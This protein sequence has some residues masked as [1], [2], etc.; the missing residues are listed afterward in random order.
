MGHRAA[1][2][3]VLVLVPVMAWAGQPGKAAEALSS[4]L[5]PTSA[6]AAATL[7]SALERSETLR[8]LAATIE[9]SDLR[10]YVETSEEPGAWR[11]GTRFVAVA[12]DV[13]M[14][15]VTLNG[16]LA[17]REKLAVLGHELQHV[18]EV[19]AD[20]TVTSQARMKQLFEQIGHL[21][22]PKGVAREN[23]Y[24]TAA[25][26]RV[27]YQVRVEVAQKKR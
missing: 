26:Q 9:T 5:R 8:T 18:C 10:V 20:L 25:A 21:V 24:E 27:E 1:A 15:T 17:P 2:V 16:S 12:G 19:A 14:L 23:V 11:G 7:A 22:N 6:A 13:R 4:R 3:G